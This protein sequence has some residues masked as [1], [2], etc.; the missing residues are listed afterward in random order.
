MKLT[1]LKGVKEILKRKDRAQKRLDALKRFESRENHD[2]IH[3]LGLKTSTSF[4][5]LNDLEIG[6][7]EL[8][9]SPLDIF[10]NNKILFYKGQEIYDMDY[11][12]KEKILD[13]IEKLEKKDKIDDLHEAV[14]ETLLIYVPKE[15][16]FEEVLLKKVLSKNSFSHIIFYFGQ[17]SKVELMYDVSSEEG[18]FIG[19]EI[20]Q[21]IVDENSEVFFGL[22]KDLEKGYYMHNKNY[23]YLH[24]NSTL[25]LLTAD[26][27]GRLIVTETYSKMIG[28][29]S[30]ANTDNLFYGKNGEEFD[31]SGSSIHANKET[32]SL[33]SLKGVLEKSKAMT[34]GLV[35]IEDNAPESNGYQKSDII[36]LDEESKA[37]SIP[38]LLIHNDQVKCSHGSTI[39][40]LEEDKIFYLQSRGLDKLTASKKLVEGFYYPM[41]E[42][43]K[44]VSFKEHIQNKIEK[45]L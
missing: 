16:V 23:A 32:S 15:S 38:D 41:L 27:G 11:E 20:V 5:N 10:E 6:F 13:T 19:A 7:D 36:L 21:I 28:K 40:H 37:V 17:R 42:K 14:S 35:K 8:S 44:N 34:R 30:T 2:R 25:N 4:A 9:G 45:R 12:G 3:G 26:F 43:I 22:V 24:D 29:N 1:D 39:S 33:I 31:V 18:D